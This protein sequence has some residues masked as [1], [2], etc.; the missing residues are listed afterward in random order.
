VCRLS[1]DPYVHGNI[2]CNSVGLFAVHGNI[3]SQ[4][5]AVHTKVLI[6]KNEGLFPL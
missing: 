6:K 1:T 4:L 2:Y 5:G 3:Y